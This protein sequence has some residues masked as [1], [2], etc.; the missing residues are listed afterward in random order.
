MGE[1]TNF[2]KFLLGN[3]AIN[4]TIQNNEGKMAVDIHRDFVACKHNQFQ[5]LENITRAQQNPHLQASSRQRVAARFYRLG[6]SYQKPIL[7]CC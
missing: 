4:T 1:R 5:R 2:T 7:G 3:Q 6:F